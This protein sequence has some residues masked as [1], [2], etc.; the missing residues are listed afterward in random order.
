MIAQIPELFECVTEEAAWS[1]TVAI[2]AEAFTGRSAATLE[3]VEPEVALF[4]ASI[5]LDEPLLEAFR[6]VPD[7]RAA[8]VFA[9]DDVVCSDDLLDE[10]PFVS[11]GVL[12]AGVVR[13]SM[14]ARFQLGDA[15]W[16]AV[17]VY[18]NAT[19]RYESDDVAAFGVFASLVGI[20]IRQ[21]RQRDELRQDARH[22]APS[23]THSRTVP[24]DELDDLSELRPTSNAVLISVEE[25]EEVGDQPGDGVGD[26]PMRRARRV[27]RSCDIGRLFRRLG[28]EEFLVPGADPVEIGRLVERIVGDIDAALRAGGPSIDISASIGAALAR[29]GDAPRSV[30][31]RVDLLSSAATHLGRTSVAEVGRV[32]PDS[33]SD[34]SRGE[35]RSDLQGATDDRHRRTDP[36]RRLPRPR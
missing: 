31:D 14:S 9:S 8:H 11:A 1:L 29:Q 4:R 28:A 18:G 22:D 21:I 16:G 24:L 25:V 20:S 13:S 36:L 10:D 7:S 3:L 12:V 33:S 26:G 5:G 17:G 34:R 27:E 32:R 15:S 6:I 19:R 35:D 30:I 23:G 2:A